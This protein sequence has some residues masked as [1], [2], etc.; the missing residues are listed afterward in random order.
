LIFQ[1]VKDRL[2]EQMLS[3]DQIATKFNFLL[4]FNSIIIAS[5]LQGLF[6]L[7]VQKSL[8]SLLIV[9]VFL[10]L[11]SAFCDL[12][13]LLLQKYRRDPDPK[14]LFEKYKDSVESE[15]KK[16][17]IQNYIESFE[18]NT[19]KLHKI[20]KIFAYSIIFLSVGLLFVFLFLSKG[21]IISIWEM[22]TKIICQK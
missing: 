21:N 9:S 10:L 7:E 16:I 12:R 20:N 2:K 5:L 13:G 11:L 6:N 18:F 22:I 3:I 1:E 4:A 19:K 15:I 14:K 17:L 8:N